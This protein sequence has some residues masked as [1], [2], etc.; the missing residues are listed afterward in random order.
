MAFSSQLVCAQ[1]SEPAD[2]QSKQ[3]KPWLDIYG[4]VMMDAGYDFKQV[5]PDWFDVVRPVKLPS[6]ENE[7]GADGN[8]YFSVRQTRFGVK[9]EV[10]TEHGPTQDPIRI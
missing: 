9:S 5:H 6:Y 10:P 3:A 2:A 7:F 4:F 1:T 8:T